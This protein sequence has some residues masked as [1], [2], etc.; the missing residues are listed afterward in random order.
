MRPGNRLGE[1]VLPG[2]SRA[3]E[4]PPITAQNPVKSRSA[5]VVDSPWTLDRMRRREA[6]GSPS[7]CP[8]VHLEGAQYAANPAEEAAM[9][10]TIRPSRAPEVARLSEVGSSAAAQS[11]F[12][13]CVDR[14]E[15]WGQT[16]G[17]QEP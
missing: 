14:G 11:R 17:G 16:K 2:P 8:W 7:V 4:N 3:R 15:L 12:H 5:V 1:R 10:L 13:S 9:P 6:V